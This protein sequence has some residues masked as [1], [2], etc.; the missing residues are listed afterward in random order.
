VDQPAE[1]FP[2]LY[3]RGCQVGDRRWVGLGVV[4]WP[5]IP[6]SVRA[7]MVIVRDVLVQDCP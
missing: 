4:W 6:G 1:D 2:A 7:M 3:L 5:Q